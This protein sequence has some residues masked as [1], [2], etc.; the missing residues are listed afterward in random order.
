[1]DGTRLVNEAVRPDEALTVLFTPTQLEEI[2]SSHKK[3]FA[4]KVEDATG[5]SRGISR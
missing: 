3:N 1:M 5:L 4:Q 2:K